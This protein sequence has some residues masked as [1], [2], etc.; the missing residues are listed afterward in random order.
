MVTFWWSIKL[1]SH[2]L[3]HQNSQFIVLFVCF[4]HA[5][6]MLLVG[7]NVPIAPQSDASC[8][9][10]SLLFVKKSDFSAK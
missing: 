7:N 3:Q 4:S 9:V 2:T 5:I 1:R 8:T 10:I 6:G